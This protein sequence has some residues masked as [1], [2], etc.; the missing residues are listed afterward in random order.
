VQIS[1]DMW[2]GWQ[3]Q[4]VAGSGTLKFDDVAQQLVPSVLKM[5]AWSTWPV[6]RRLPVL[7][8]S[9]LEVEAYHPAPANLWSM[10][11]EHPSQHCCLTVPQADSEYSPCQDIVADELSSPC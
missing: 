8:V 10:Y 2:T 4:A 5:A 9:I 6:P 11:A 7:V 1:R 3:W